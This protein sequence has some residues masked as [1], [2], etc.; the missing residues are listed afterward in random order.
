MTSLT[1]PPLQELDFEQCENGIYFDNALAEAD[2]ILSCAELFPIIH[3]KKA[4]EIKGK[5]HETL[6]WVASKLLNFS[7][8]TINYGV[9]FNE[10]VDPESDEGCPDYLRVITN[11]MDLGTISNRVFLDYYRASSAFFVDLGFIF[12]NCRQYHKDAATDIRILCDTLRE[13]SILIYNE[14][15]EVEARRY[16][17]LRKEST[18]ATTPISSNGDIAIAVS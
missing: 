7:K 8:D 14:W 10:P 18:E 12:K 2:R 6:T 9:F 15:H 3:P 4:N 11:P 5:W 1:P 16:A 17:I 13:A